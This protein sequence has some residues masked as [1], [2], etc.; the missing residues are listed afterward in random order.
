MEKGKEIENNWNNNQLNILINNCINIE[1]NI[2]NI[3]LL[4]ESIVKTNNLKIDINFLPKEDG[5]NQL[6]DSIKKFGEIIKTKFGT[7]IDF[8]EKLVETWL[9]N[10]KFEPIYYI[11]NQ[12]MV[13]IQMISIVGVI[14]KE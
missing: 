4:N 10:R 9:Y 5:V 1:N 2:R 14:I 8:D 3:K 11:E 6:L 13:Q 12:E 7:N